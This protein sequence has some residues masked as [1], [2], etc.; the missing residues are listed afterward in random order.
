M[1]IRSVWRVQLV[2][3]NSVWGVRKRQTCVYVAFGESGCAKH[4]YAYR[5]VSPS[6][7]DMCVCVA[8]GE[9]GVTE[10]VYA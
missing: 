1:C 4:L 9:P 6:S 7:P 3:A 2:W 8:F 5:F 10:H